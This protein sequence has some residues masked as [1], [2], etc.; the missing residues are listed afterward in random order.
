MSKYRVILKA[1]AYF[2]IDVEADNSERALEE[3]YDKAPTLCAHCVGWGKD[4]GLELSG[5]WDIEEDVPSIGYYGV[6]KIED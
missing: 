6:E 5:E 1:N 3:A 2:T 4:W